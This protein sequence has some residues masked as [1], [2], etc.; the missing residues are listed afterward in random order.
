MSNW[1]VR[2]SRERFWA[3][4]MEQDKINAYMTLYTA[5]VTVAKAAA[6]MIPFMTEDI[7]QNLVQKHRQDRSGEHPS[8]RFPGSQMKRM[9]DKQLESDM[10]EVL[11]IVVYGPCMQE[12]PQ[13]SR[14]VSRLARCMLR[15]KTSCPTS[16]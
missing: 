4:G 9:I 14:T 16:M 8:V 7:Y 1:Y 2:R 11:K 10:D 12:I 15:Q 5:L 13:T 3:K 6:P